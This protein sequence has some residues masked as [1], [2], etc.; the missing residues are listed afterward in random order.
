MVAHYSHFKYYMVIYMG[1][2]PFMSWGREP[3]LNLYHIYSLQ[4]LYL[5]STYLKAHQERKK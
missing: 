5:N 3:H 1:K 2:K 4:A